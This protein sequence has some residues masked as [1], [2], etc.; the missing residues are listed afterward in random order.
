MYNKQMVIIEKIKSTIKKYAM[1]S[2]GDRVLVGLSGGPD[3]VCLLKM[4]NELKTEYGIELFAAYIDHGLRP[5]ETPVEIDFCKRLCA[6]L[7]IS[8]SIEAIDVK[9]LVRERGL[10]KQEA[11]RELRYGTLDALS[12]GINANKIA[13]GHNAD[14][15]AETVLMR[16]VRGAGLSGI[17]GI[18]PVR[19]L[20]SGRHIIRPLIEVERP[21]IEGFLCG[22]GTTSLTDSSN[23]QDHYLR[24]RIR[25][26]IMPAVK[27]LNKNAVK[28]IARASDIFRDDERYFELLTTK[29]LMRMI[30]RKTDSSVEL[31][32]APMETMEKVILRRLL[33]RALDETK[34]L[35][36]ISFVHIE[37]IVNLVRSGRSGSRLHVP[38]DIRVIKGYSTLIITSDEPAKLGSYVIDGP[39]ETALKES[40]MVLRC[41][42][43]DL[44]GHPGEYDYG[45]GR[46]TALIDADK[47]RF[48]L[49]VRPRTPGDY[50]YPLGLGRRKKLQDYLVDEKAPRDQRDSIPLLINDNEIAWVVGYRVD[51]R[52]KVDKNTKRGLKFDIK[53]LKF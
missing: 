45:D 48:P 20:A 10:N 21:E 28:A 13:L 39:G 23:L 14:D 19:R 49:S 35:R 46:R 2:G 42:I 43:I 52:Y 18:P 8:L 11:A 37:D 6:P 22:N 38:K 40:S 32:L 33:R 30:S 4:L 27:S 36:G 12:S 7:G 17:S 26:T 31:F 47:V 50:F 51:E 16:L 1:L 9:S 41:S 44:D 3:S 5:A 25:H 34:S 53:P 15:Q 24:N 29:T